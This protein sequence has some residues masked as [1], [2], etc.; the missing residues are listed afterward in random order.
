M[1][2][3]V[4]DK[5]AKTGAT[6]PAV[7][8]VV[9][10]GAS[11][12][13]LSVAYDVFGTDRSAI[14]GAP[15]YR[16]LVCGAEPGMVTMDGGLQIGV[17]HGLDAIT[18]VDTVIVAPTERPD[19][20]PEAT[21]R[22]LNDAHDRGC[23]IISLCTG[24][25]ILAGAG[26]LDGRRVTTHWFECDRLA[27]RYPQ[28]TVD[29]RVLFVDDGDILTSAGSAASIDL[30][31][32]LVRLDHGSAV[33][34]QVAR[35]MV[36]P[37]QRDGGQAQFIE[38]PM[39]ALD[40]SNMLADTV[41]WLQEHIDEPVT[42]DDLAARSAMSPRTFARRFRAGTGT[43]PYQW[44]L[45]QRLQLAQRLLETTDLSIDTVAARSGLGTAANLRKH[46]GR[47]VDISP[48]SYRRTFKD[49]QTP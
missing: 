18:R 45:R 34:A 15:L 27:E 46:F 49:R 21:Y 38:T 24:A 2:D 13:E 3:M 5:P 48:Q 32:H 39:P 47:V 4:R 6:R 40:S 19:D 33:A 36:V 17:P 22:A 26:L 29:P 9:H 10:E 28:L 25:F 12:F 1:I 20:V 31:L 11:L 41:T 8:V 35:D 44:M 16:L 37:P 43:T 23:R 14:F 42:I 30:C 7:A